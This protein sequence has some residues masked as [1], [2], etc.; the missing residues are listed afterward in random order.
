MAILLN[1]FKISDQEFAF[2]QF[3]LGSTEELFWWN[4][5]KIV[6][7]HAQHTVECLNCMWV[8]NGHI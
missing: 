6:N 2:V 1:L 8:S 7:K 3:S 5:N 4:E